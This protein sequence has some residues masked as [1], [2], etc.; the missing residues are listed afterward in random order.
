MAAGA[1]PL[2]AR[3]EGR[4]EGGETLQD[5][6]NR[7]LGGGRC[8][9]LRLWRLRRKTERWWR[10]RAPETRAQLR[11]TPPWTPASSGGSRG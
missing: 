6:V 2:D 1:S 9:L 7:P 10:R 4:G 8:L 3:P 5:R 11:V